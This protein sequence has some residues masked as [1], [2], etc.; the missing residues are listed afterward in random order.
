MFLPVWIMVIMVSLMLGCNGR[1]LI[2]SI[3]P[4]DKIVI[5]CVLP[6]NFLLKL[7]H[8]LEQVMAD[9]LYLAIEESVPSLK[10]NSRLDGLGQNQSMDIPVTNW[11]KWLIDSIAYPCFLQA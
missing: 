1:F 2:W 11:V 10:M 4:P 5:F 6:T 3:T 9:T 8:V 7:L